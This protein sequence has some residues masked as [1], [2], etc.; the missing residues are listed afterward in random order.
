MKA[1]DLKDL[2]ELAAQAGSEADKKQA[3]AIKKSNDNK[4]VRRTFSLGSAHD[5]L[6]NREA[7]KL[8]K[9]L[10]KPVGASE[11]L[12]VLIERGASK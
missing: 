5:K 9:E 12:R 4:I 7:A 3:R 2:S 11:A 10:G 8:S 6:I 1:P